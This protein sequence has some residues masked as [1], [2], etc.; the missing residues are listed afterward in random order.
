MTSDGET[1]R[2]VICTEPRRISA[3]S[4]ADRVSAELGETSGPGRH[5]S[6]CGYQIRFESRQSK[7]TRLTYCTTGVLLRRLHDDADLRDVACII[8]DEVGYSSPVDCFSDLLH[9]SLMFYFLSI[10]GISFC[11]SSRGCMLSPVHTD[12]K[13]DCSS[14]SSQNALGVGP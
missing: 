10:T 13:V 14:G 12:D 8:V 1:V 6:L 7:S 5:E 3:V 4:L 9:S 11:F 2:H